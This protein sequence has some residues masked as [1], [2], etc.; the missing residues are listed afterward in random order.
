[1]SLFSRFA[2]LLL[3]L[4]G[5]LLLVMGC[6]NTIDPLRQDAG[7]SIYGTLSMNDA[8]HVVR[9]RDLSTPFT[10]E[11]TE[12]LDVTVTLNNNATGE[13]IPMRDSVVAFDGVF[14]HNFRARASLDHDA[15]YSVVVEDPEGTR[16]TVRTRT[17][18]VTQVRSQPDSA[19]CLGFF[20]VTFAPVQSKS[21]MDIDVGYVYNGRRTWIDITPSEYDLNGGVARF[22]FLAEDVL[23]ETVPSQDNPATVQF[24]EPRCRALD[25]N[26][27]FIAYTRF[28]RA[29]RTTGDPYDPSQSGIVENGLGSLGVLFRDT[30]FVKVDTVNAIRVF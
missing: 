28:G 29:G 2:C 26:R 13:R 25:D 23:S 21:L 8:V 17:P 1:M 27:I 3:A 19:N 22:L 12:D 30:T 15:Q 14:T 16:T 18:P 5:T 10:A 20:T 11:A 6:E 7:Y 24:L 9:V 4:A